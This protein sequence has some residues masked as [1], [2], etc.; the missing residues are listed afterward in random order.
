M[1]IAM[2]GYQFYQVLSHVQWT[3]SSSTCLRVGSASPTNSWQDH[4]GSDADSSL[5]SGLATAIMT[6]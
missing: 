4:P 3:V 5:T 6:R 1:T 2:K